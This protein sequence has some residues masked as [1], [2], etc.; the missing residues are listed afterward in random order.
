MTTNLDYHNTYTS[1]LHKTVTVIG[2]WSSLFTITETPCILF[3]LFS[4]RSLWSFSIVPNQ[5][6]PWLWWNA[7]NKRMMYKYLDFERFDPDYG[8]NNLF[9]I[10]SPQSLYTLAR[11]SLPPILSEPKIFLSLKKHLLLL[12]L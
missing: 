8:W 1:S 7:S 12:D 6:D 3:G 4:L 2:I 11:S 5:E 10:P 9:C